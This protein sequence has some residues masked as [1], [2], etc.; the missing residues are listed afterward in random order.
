MRGWRQIPARL[1]YGATIVG[2]GLV[3]ARGFQRT[4]DEPDSAAARMVPII[5]RTF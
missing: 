1:V 5:G 3:V 2:L 4:F